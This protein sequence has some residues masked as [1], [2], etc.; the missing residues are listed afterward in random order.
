M[1]NKGVNAIAVK[2]RKMAAGYLCGDR[3]KKD[4][5]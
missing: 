2:L 1:G 5:N 4:N 3:Y